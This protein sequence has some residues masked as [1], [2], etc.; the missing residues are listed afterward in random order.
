MN[1][2]SQFFDRLVQ[3][4]RYSMQDFDSM[5]TYTIYLPKQVG[6]VSNLS[7]RYNCIE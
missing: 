3:K 2:V 1:N 6:Q 7:S 5:V 4:S